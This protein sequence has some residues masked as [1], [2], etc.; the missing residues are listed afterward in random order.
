MYNI[1]DY[2][3]YSTAGICKIS[4][5]KTEEFYG[6]NKT[7]YIIENVYGNK[8]VVHVPKDNE[9]IM[10]KIRDLHTKKDIDGFLEKAAK[11]AV[12]WISEYKLRNET[13]TATLK[14]NDFFEIAKVL[15]LSYINE[16]E[17]ISMNKK[18]SM[19]DKKVTDTA[20]KLIFE[21][22]ATV[23]D[24]PYDNVKEEIVKKL[25]V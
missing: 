10:S 24:V 8:S 17:C 2:V 3:V 14:S 4:D 25:N 21:E 15:K 12:S 20:E 7:Y 16:K 18:I 19:T 6:D 11:T 1:G 5:I 22:Y 9:L 13:H 23:F